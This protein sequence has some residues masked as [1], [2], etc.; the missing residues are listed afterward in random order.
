MWRGLDVATITFVVSYGNDHN[1]VPESLRQAIMMLA[2][3]WFNQR[4]AAVIGPE[5]GPA[6]HIPFSVREILDRM[7]SGLENRIE[8]GCTSVGPEFPARQRASRPAPSRCLQP[9]T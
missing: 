8:R 3:Y 7:I 6:S 2:A 1:A 4:E 5:Q 9:R